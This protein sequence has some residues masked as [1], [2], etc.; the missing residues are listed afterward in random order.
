MRFWGFRQIFLKTLRTS[1]PSVKS[2][3]FITLCLVDETNFSSNEVLSLKDK[4]Q[5]HEFGHFLR[6]AHM[7]H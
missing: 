4:T 6:I 5:L 2:L 7:L 1:I 3:L